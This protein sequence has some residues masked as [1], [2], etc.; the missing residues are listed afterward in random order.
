MITIRNTHSK[1][2]EPEEE[3]EEG[4]HNEE[5]RLKEHRNQVVEPLPLEHNLH[6]QV[7]A[8]D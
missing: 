5:N 4:N 3:G 6:L 7:K 8:Y 2:C 1:V